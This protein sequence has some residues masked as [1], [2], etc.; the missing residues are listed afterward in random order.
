MID[1]LDDAK[2]RARRVLR[3]LNHYNQPGALLGTLLTASDPLHD[4]DVNEV[5]MALIDAY[6]E[7]ARDVVGVLDRVEVDIDRCIAI[8]GK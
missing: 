7:G 4:V 3:R 1:G 6:T 8:L 5:A 2:N